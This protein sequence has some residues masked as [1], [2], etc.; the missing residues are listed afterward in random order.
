MED[1]QGFLERPGELAEELLEYGFK[2]MKIWPFDRVAP[3]RGGS[4]L[5]AE[6]LARGL[7]PI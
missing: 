6:G 2:A 7:A 1:L 3:E 4:I 5:D